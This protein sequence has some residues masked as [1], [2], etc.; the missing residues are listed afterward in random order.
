MTKLIGLGAG[1]GLVSALLFSVVATGSPAGLLLCYAAPLPIIIVSLGWSHLLGLL[2]VAVGGLAISLGLSDAAAI[3]FAIGPALPAWAISYALLGGFGLAR[4]G[5]AAAGTVSQP[6]PRHL[7][8]YLLVLVAFAGA[9]VALVSAVALGD[10]DFATYRATL[11]GVAESL[12]RIE[13]GTA[14]NAAL[15][16]VAGVA[17]SD[18]VSL[19]IRI[20]PAVAAAVFSLAFALNLWIGARAVALS[21]RLPC[22]WSPVPETRMPLGALAAVVVGLLL[23]FVPGFVGVGGM[24][25]LGALMMAFA[26]QGLALLHHVTRGRKGRGPLLTFAYM[27]TIFFGGTFLPLMALAGMADTATPLR[28]RL[29]SRAAKTKPPAPPTN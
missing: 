26:L 11:K 5:A 29:L 1:A 2:A 20:A 6:S 3:A 25:L 7:P 12:L 13:T 14:R 16:D 8:G 19:L 10:G 22:P 9:T 21:G 15:P 24:T 17:A 28:S 27:L 18:L 4:P 23:V